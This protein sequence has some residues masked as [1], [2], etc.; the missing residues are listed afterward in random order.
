M[1]ANDL[2]GKLLIDWISKL[3][4]TIGNPER[5][6]VPDLIGLLNNKGLAID[7]PRLPFDLNSIAIVP[8]AE[9]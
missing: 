8:A 5:L 2:A 4:D 9:P 3:Y 1:D 6:G 7:P